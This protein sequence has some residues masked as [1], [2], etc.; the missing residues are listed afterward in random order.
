MDKPLNVGFIGLGAMG[1]PMAANLATKLPEGSK[2]YVF[3]IFK[4]ALESFTKSHPTS[5]EICDSPRA[6]AE[7]AEIILT[8]VPE[9]SHVRSVYLDPNTGILTHPSLASHLL[10]DCS[11]IDT[12]TSS[13]VHSR[14]ASRSPTASFFDAPVS[15]GTLGAEKATL[16]FMLG[17][18]ES[19]PQFPLLNSLLT[20]A[21]AEAMNIG[22]RSGM[23][24]RLLAKVFSSSTAQSTICDKWNPVPGV[25]PEAPSS[26]GYRGGFKVQLMK[27]DFG[28]AVEAGRG[29]GSEDGAGRGGVEGCSGGWGGD[30]EWEEKLAKKG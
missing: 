2:V 17:S 29:S 15:G 21:T 7:H 22:M 9:G 23:D 24:P 19:S 1:Y 10:I 6:V 25:V 14:I 26:N 18:S 3:D 30:E 28:L 11:T 27:K 13:L 16:T 4:G 8:M 5:S 20:L 12:E